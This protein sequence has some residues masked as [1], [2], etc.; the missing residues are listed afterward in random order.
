MVVHTS[1]TTRSRGLHIARQYEQKKHRGHF[2][3]QNITGA[4]VF[5]KNDRRRNVDASFRH[6]LSTFSSS[7]CA[8]ADADANAELGSSLC[9]GVDSLEVSSVR[10]EIRILFRRQEWLIR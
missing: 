7:C 10:I 3:S 1:H 9:R 4:A 5:I 8:D 6:F 2:S